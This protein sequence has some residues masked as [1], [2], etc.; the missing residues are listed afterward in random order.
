MT[1][2][3]LW[4]ALWQEILSH[5]VSDRVCFLFTSHFLLLRPFRWI[6]ALCSFSNF[7]AC[8]WCFIFQNISWNDIC[9]SSIDEAG[10]RHHSDRLPVP[11]HCCSQQYEQCRSLTRNTL[12]A[13][14][15][16]VQKLHVRMF[17]N[18]LKFSLTYY[19]KIFSLREAVHVT[20]QGM[21]VHL[22]CV[23]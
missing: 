22:W 4:N 23:V 17:E 9:S 6:K 19:G 18:A 16:K 11:G 2:K 14:K 20:L 21:D 3:R 1:A 12:Q 7:S 5:P 13:Q 15:K 8:W 10:L